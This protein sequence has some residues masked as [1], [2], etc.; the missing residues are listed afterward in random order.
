MKNTVLQHFLDQQNTTP[1]TALKL[2]TL[3]SPVTDSI[4]SSK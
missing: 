2:K 1:D 3:L 4:L